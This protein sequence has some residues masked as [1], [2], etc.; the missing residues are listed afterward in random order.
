[1]TRVRLF[2]LCIVLV[3]ALAC[4]TTDIL[5]SYL[6]PA[7]TPPRARTLTRTAVPSPVQPTLPPAAVV[8]TTPPEIPGTVTENSSR[9]RSAPSTGGAILTRLNKGDQIT[10]VGKNVSSDWFEIRLPSDPN[11]RG[12]I[13]ADLVQLQGSADALPVVQPGGIPSTPRP[14]PRP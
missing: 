12:W 7:P 4:Q 8:P 1:M 13:S 14:Y 6:S 9:V 2:S 10:V 11:G 5:S 3:S